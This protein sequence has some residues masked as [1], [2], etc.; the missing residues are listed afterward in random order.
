MAHRV[1]PLKNHQNRKITLIAE[2]KSVHYHEMISLLAIMKQGTGQILDISHK[3]LSFG[4]LYPHTF[5]HEFYLDLLSA[6]GNHIR[7]VKVRKIKETNGDLFE[8]VV[9]VEFAELS[10]SQAKEMNYLFESPLCFKL[11]TNKRRSD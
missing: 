5:P 9:G 8:L 3:G 1:D 6:R 11:Q 4:C 2:Q 7:K 10:A